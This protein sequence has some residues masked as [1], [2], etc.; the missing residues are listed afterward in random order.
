[1]EYSQQERA[2]DDEYAAR[3]ERQPRANGKWHG[4]QEGQQEKEKNAS[5][6]RI[7]SFDEI[8]LEAN[9]RP[10]LVHGLIPTNGLAVAWGPPKCGKTFTV[11]DM[12]MHIALGWDYRGRK[13]QQGA[14]VYCSF[15]GQSGLAGRI[16]AFRQHCLPEDPDPIP[17][18]AVTTTLDLARQVDDLISSIR[19]ACI[20]PTV[21]C[22]DTLNRSISGS[23]NSD[24]DMGNYIA[25]CDKIRETLNC[26]VVIVHHCGVEGSRPRGH[27]SLTGACDAQL[28][29]TRDRNNNCEMRVQFMKDGGSE[30]EVVVSTLKAVEVARDADDLPI[31]SCIVAAAE[32]AEAGP[33]ERKLTA[34]QNTMLGLLREGMPGGLLTEE[35]NA[36]ARVEGIGLKRRSDLGD[37]RRALKEKGLVHAYA[38]RWFIT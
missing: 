30:G 5:K 23:E 15:E 20:E 14:V 7:L 25:A 21:V 24:Q 17:F 38:D 37:L 26:A 32:V 12:L 31:T 33:K 27:T 36:K 18:H 11:T 9:Y 22:L 19:E 3:D 1:M 8:V 16:E 35:W 28:A 29:F 13:V 34:N 2:R 6:V 10:Y 4:K